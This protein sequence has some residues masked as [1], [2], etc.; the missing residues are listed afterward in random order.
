MKPLR[1]SLIS[2]AVLAITIWSSRNFP[3]TRHIR[4]DSGQ[5]RQFLN[6]YPND[7]DTRFLGGESR[8]LKEG[9]RS[10]L[11][12]AMYKAVHGCQFQKTYRNILYW[13]VF[14]RV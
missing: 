9:D 11:S 6:V 10:C 4:D 13:I 5:I 1:C 3:P 2:T 7:E 8:S 12:I 14:L